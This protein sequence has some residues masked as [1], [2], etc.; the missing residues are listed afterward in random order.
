[1][2]LHNSGYN[3]ESQASTPFVSGP[4]RVCAIEAIKN[5]GLLLTRDTD[6]RIGD[7]DNCPGIYSR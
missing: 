4:R 3:G 2:L 1:M 5:A 7:D 6:A